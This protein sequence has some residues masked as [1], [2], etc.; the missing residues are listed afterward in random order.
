[1]VNQLE[2]MHNIQYQHDRQ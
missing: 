2:R 1:M